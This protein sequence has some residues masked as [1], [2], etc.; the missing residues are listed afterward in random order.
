M[1]A[2][3]LIELIDLSTSKRLFV[4]FLGGLEAERGTLRSRFGG[5]AVGDKSGCE[6]T[7]QAQPLACRALVPLTVQHASNYHFYDASVVQ[8]LQRLL[9]Q[10][11]RSG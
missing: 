9:L 6:N 8:V 7:Y 2:G 3:L 4:P 11:S 10:R 1:Y 5:A